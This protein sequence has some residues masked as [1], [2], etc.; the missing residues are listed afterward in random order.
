MPLLYHITISKIEVKHAADLRHIITNKVF[1]SLNKQYKDENNFL[2]YL[3]VIE[4]EGALSK[5]I[6]NNNKNI[7]GRGEH[8]HIVI[9]T[10]IPQHCI[11]NKIKEVFNSK[12]DCLIQPISDRNDKENLINYIL[13]QEKL[14][15]KENYNY[16]ILLDKLPVKNIC[17]V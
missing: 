9:S 16:K 14:L 13:K 6:S 12:Y 5:P 11:E 7:T 4:Y 15:S 8:A 10:S 2:N 3:F 1:N 17:L